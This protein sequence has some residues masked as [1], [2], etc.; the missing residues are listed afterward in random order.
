MAVRLFDVGGR[1]TELSAEG[2]DLEL[3]SGVINLEMLRSALEA[4]GL[5]RSARK[6]GVCSNAARWS[7]PKWRQPQAA[8][9]ERPLPAQLC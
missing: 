7:P 4:T 5:A 2:D 1:L 6:A 9:R 3:L 8:R